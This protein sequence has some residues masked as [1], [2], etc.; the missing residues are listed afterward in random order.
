V[1]AFTRLGWQ[2]SH[3]RAPRCSSVQAPPATLGLEPMGGTVVGRG[4]PPSAALHR[5][6]AATRGS[7]R[8]FHRSGARSP[9]RYV[10]PSASRESCS[11][12]AFARWSWYGGTQ[13]SRI[14]GLRTPLG[15]AG[16]LV[17]ANVRR[18]R[19]RPSPREGTRGVGGFGAIVAR[20]RARTFVR[21]RG[22]VCARSRSRAREILCV[23]PDR[24]AGAFGTERTRFAFRPGQFGTR[25]LY[26]WLR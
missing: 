4:S 25:V 9:S 24:I 19:P 13:A 16:L 18:S 11:R 21:F 14:E 10:R 2:R 1:G 5:R 23:W 12:P 22:H 20:R 17:A 7:R 26:A 3:H 6:H 15:L 8:N